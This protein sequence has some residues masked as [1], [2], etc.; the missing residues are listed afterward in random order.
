MKGVPGNVSPEA[1]Q[2]PGL[3]TPTRALVRVERLSPR[4][5]GNAKKQRAGLAFKI[6]KKKATAAAW[7]AAGWGF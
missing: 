4:R 3:P 1:R 2:F 6:K 5:A 7:E